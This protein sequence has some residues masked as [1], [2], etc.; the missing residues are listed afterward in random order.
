MGFG[1][2]RNELDY[3]KFHY[4]PETGQT[5]EPKDYYN[6]Y[7]LGIGIDYFIQFNAGFTIKNITSEIGGYF[8]E[9]ES[10]ASAKAERTITD[11]GLL[12][13][14]PI[15]KLIDQDLFFGM[16]AGNKLIPFFNF[17][18]GYS[19]SNIGDSIYYLDPA[20]S[21]PLPRIDRLGYGIKTGIDLVSDD[22]RINTISLS[23]TAEA[24]DIIISRDTTGQWSYQSTLSD[25]HLWKNIINVEGDGWIVSHAGYKIDLFETISFSGG[26][27]SGRGFDVRKSNGYEI[28]AKG[29]FKLYALWADNSIT[30]FL[31]DHFDIAYYHTNFFSGHP[32][33][34]EM[35]GLALYI[36]NLDSLF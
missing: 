4:G 17:S 14:V 19:K 26:H 24:D 28:R 35:T 2:S 10:H 33:V 9:E 30:D 21:D 15:I 31:R 5:S 8:V 23:F 29:L 3:G 27:F 20:Q 34:T 1:Y 12:I 22:F 7:S 16:N 32:L 13:N 18:T 6:A 36:S 25:L 11:F